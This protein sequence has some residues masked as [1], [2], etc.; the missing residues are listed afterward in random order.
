MT[1]YRRSFN[2]MSGRF[3]GHRHFPGLWA[4][5]LNLGAY[6]VLAKPFDAAEV[7]ARVSLAVLYWR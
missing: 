4:E 6:D 7:T 2:P 3:I 5:A 1:Q